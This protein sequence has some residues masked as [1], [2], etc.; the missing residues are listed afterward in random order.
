MTSGD[1]AYVVAPPIKAKQLWRHRATGQL[2]RVTSY[3]E[4]IDKVLYLGVYPPGEVHLLSAGVMVSDGVSFRADFSPQFEQPKTT[5]AKAPAK[6]AAAKKPSP[7]SVLPKKKK[8]PEKDLVKSILA[9]LELMP[10]VVAW[11]NNT[12]AFKAE[13]K[14]KTKR[15]FVSFGAPGSGDIFVVIGPQGFFLSVEAKAKTK[16]RATQ[17]EWRRK[18]I[19][20]GAA[21]IVVHTVEAVVQVVLA[22][23]REGASGLSA[24]ARVPPALRAA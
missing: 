17:R 11:R 20:V 23:Q 7:Q 15:K 9:R 4:L 10:H 12:G 24:A 21:S 14:G 6:K 5:R 13:A 1:L 2:V 19:G 16:E 18:M 8:S 3:M 22:I